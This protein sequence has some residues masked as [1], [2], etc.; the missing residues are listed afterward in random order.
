MNEKTEVT[1]LREKKNAEFLSDCA[2]GRWYRIT[3]FSEI[4]AEERRLADMGMVPGCRVCVLR[5]A[6]SGDPICL[7]ALDFT[8][9]LRL[10]EAAKIRVASD[11]GNG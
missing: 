6:P 5:R 9:T 1:V 3:G 7:R 10:G 4:G 11:D 8:L 2:C